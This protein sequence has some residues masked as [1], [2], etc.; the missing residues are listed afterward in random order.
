[1]SQVAGVESPGCLIRDAGTWAEG[2]PL[3]LSGASVGLLF[4]LPS[5]PRCHASRAPSS[6]RDSSADRQPQPCLPSLA[7][8]LPEP[9]LFPPCLVPRHN[10]C[11]FG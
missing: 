4:S 11:E 5:T 3:L 8:F 1:M 9:F 7:P 10:F 2:W 6:Q